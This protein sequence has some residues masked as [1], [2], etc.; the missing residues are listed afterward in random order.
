MKWC[1]QRDASHSLKTNLLDK[2]FPT[3]APRAP[4]DATV[5]PRSPR[6]R[7]AIPH[8]ATSVWF[9]LSLL[10]WSIKG[11]AIYNW[12]EIITVLSYE[13][14][15]LTEPFCM[16]IRLVEC[17]NYFYVEWGTQNWKKVGN[18]RFRSRCEVL[19]VITVNITAFRDV[20]PYRFVGIYH[21][22]GGGG[23]LL[24]QSSG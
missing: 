20:M 12:S 8:H 17:T 13:L 22:F 6:I 14:S 4:G 3:C 24:H 2:Y 5:I 15:Q 1:L 21:S 7:M 23:E 10:L 18:R 16:A 9:H 19:M 11:K